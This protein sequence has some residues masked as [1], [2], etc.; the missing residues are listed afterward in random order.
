M[1]EY[2]ELDSASAQP[3]QQHPRPPGMPADWGLTPLGLLMELAGLVM[4]GVGAAIA[5]VGLFTAVADGGAA[6]LGVLFGLTAIVRSQLHRRA[7]SALLYGD[8]RGAFHGLKRYLVFAFAH[9]L[10]A[11]LLLVPIMPPGSKLTTSILLAIWLIAWPAAVALL[12]R[13]TPFWKPENDL[14]Q[15]PLAEDH[16]YESLSIVMIILAAFGITVS[17]SVALLLLPLGLGGHLMVA[18]PVLAL[19]AYRS[20]L[21]VRAAR[22]GLGGEGGVP[23]EERGMR[24]SNAGIVVAFAVSAATL[25][26]LLITG[27]LGPTV[28]LAPIAVFWLLFMWPRIVGDFLQKRSYA[29][30]VEGAGRP[31]SRAP[32]LGLSALGWL[33]VGLGVPTLAANLVML[34]GGA[35]SSDGLGVL[36]FLSSGEGLWVE[37]AVVAASALKVWAGTEIVCMTPRWRRSAVLYAVAGIAA[38]VWAGW[39]QLRL[40]SDLGPRALSSGAEEAIGALLSLLPALI[41]PVATLLLMKRH[42]VAPARAVSD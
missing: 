6:W 16:G 10:A 38:V 28:F 32:D 40:L 33:L 26:S 3:S 21:H 31:T 30:F 14:S 17:A 24:Y 20:V 35:L 12:A 22:L 4:L 27:A 5:C 8:P 1:D 37:L 23:F 11:P 19:F 39:D 9:S 18:I 2:P 34:A 13:R 15:L 42:R 29:H 36:A 25:L 7:G 41:L